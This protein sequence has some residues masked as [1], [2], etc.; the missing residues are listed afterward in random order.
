MEGSS[1]PQN[2]EFNIDRRYE[3]EAAI[4]EEKMFT[5]AMCTADARKA[6]EEL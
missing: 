5:P 3:V 1:E 6:V 2:L 4:R